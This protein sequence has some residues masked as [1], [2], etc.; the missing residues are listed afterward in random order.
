MVAESFKKVKALCKNNRSDLFIAGIIFFTGMASF[1]LGRISVLWESPAPLFVEQGSDESAQASGRQAKEDTQ[2]DKR[3]VASRTG[4]V[5]HYSWCPGAT[6]IKE[7]NKIW[8]PT[9]DD[10]KKAGLKPATNCSGL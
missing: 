6:R 4:S 7:E 2:L 3:V 9:K 10:A 1:G 8:F 5:Y